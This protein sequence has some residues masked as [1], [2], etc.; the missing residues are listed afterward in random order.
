MGFLKFVGFSEIISVGD[1]KEFL[2]IPKIGMARKTHTEEVASGGFDTVDLNNE[3]ALLEELAEVKPLQRRPNLS[4]IAMDS[5][6]IWEM[7]VKAKIDRFLAG[8]I[9]IQSETGWRKNVA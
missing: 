2:A 4:M 6:A 9:Q 1:K 7:S 3:K 5:K 8:R